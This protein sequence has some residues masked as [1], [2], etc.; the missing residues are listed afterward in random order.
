MD[1]NE[2]TSAQTEGHRSRAP[3]D[4]PGPRLAERPYAAEGGRPRKTVTGCIQ[5]QHRPTRYGVG[6]GGKSI[7]IDQ[8]AR[9]H[10]GRARKTGRAGDYHGA[11]AVL[12]DTARGAVAVV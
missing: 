3:F 11:I 10:G 9:Q 8:S 5:L 6:R 1:I 7:G 4:G 2:R 12:A